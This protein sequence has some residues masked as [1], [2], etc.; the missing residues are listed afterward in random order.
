MNCKL[1]LLYQQGGLRQ[2]PVNDNELKSRIIAKYSY[3]D[4]DEDHREHHPIQPKSV[5]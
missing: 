1:V 4:R 3:V 5:S 2:K